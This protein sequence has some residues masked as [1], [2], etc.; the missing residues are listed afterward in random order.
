[1]LLAAVG[2]ALQDGAAAKPVRASVLSAA[3]HTRSEVAAVAAAAAHGISSLQ[4]SKTIAAV[5]QRTCAAAIASMM[6]VMAAASILP[7]H[8]AAY[9]SVAV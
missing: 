9:D 8:F 4:I 1:M 7:L 3:C 5:F 2:A 6:V